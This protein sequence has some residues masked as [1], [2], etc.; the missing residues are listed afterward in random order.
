MAAGRQIDNAMKP[1]K[2]S[3]KEG[4][5]IQS[6]V[7]VCGEE[8]IET[9][10]DRRKFFASDLYES[11]K[12][13][14]IIVAPRN[15]KELS[16]IVKI[17]HEA[18]RPIYVRG[19][20]MSYSNS[21]LPAKETSILL[22]SRNMKAI[23]DINTRDLYATVECGCT[24]AE[25]DKAL[26]P[27][28]LRAIFWGPYSGR[29]ATIGGGLSQGS[30]NNAAAKIGTSDSA[31]LGYEIVTGTGDILQTGK[32]SQVG[33]K[34][35]TRNYGPDITSLF[36]NDAGALGIKS[37]VTLKLEPR[38]EAFGGVSFAFETFEEVLSAVKIIGQSGQASA[39]IAMDAKTAGIRAGKRGWSEDLTK[40]IGV[41]KSAH[42]PLLGLI[43]GLKIAMAGRQVF[44]RANFTAH[45]LA[46]G[47][48]DRILR[49]AEKYLRDKVKPFGNEIPS[50]AISMMRLED[51]P[52]LPLTHIDGR[53]M[54]PVHGI[55]PLSAM[56]DYTAAYFDMMAGYEA[57]MSEAQITV[58][59]IFTLINSNSLL[60]EPVFYWPD[61]HTPYHRE[62]SSDLWTENW[63]KKIED[64]LVARA[65]VEEI[66]SAMIDLLFEHGAGHI[67][68]GK[69][70]PYLRG[71]DEVTTKFLK[72][73]KVRLDPD[74]IINP[75]ALGL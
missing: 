73:I 38:P 37:A 59:D 67:Q 24:W 9:D 14:D 30:A 3:Q 62:M 48:N 34:P 41:M 27:Q 11:G 25:L 5:L 2:S 71:R 56:L 23:R 53:R 44:K 36:S 45:F 47:A 65:L 49:T 66:K 29:K 50:I 18:Q 32:D 33:H 13:P 69:Q 63:P 46:E 10:E 55:L 26:K 39:I 75:G 22:D 15:S 6:L 43:R 51:F 31:V 12:L 16:E 20:G 61:S 1:I 52:D 54:L 42:N 68:I 7:G 57:A 19:G 58:A 40:L 64:N 60:C 17:A 70:Y 8:N 74:N 4:E 21:F 35:F 72:E 28:G